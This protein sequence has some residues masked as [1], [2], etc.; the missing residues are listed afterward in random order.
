MKCLESIGF[1]EKSCN[2]FANY[3]NGRTQ[4]VVTDGYQATF[5]SVNK[6]VPQGSILGPFLF[7]IFI[8]KLGENVRN[9]TIRLYADDAILYTIVPSVDRMVQN[10]NI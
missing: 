1:D 2:W 10:L 4:A 6:G 7:T 3:L 8:N 5:M 9:N